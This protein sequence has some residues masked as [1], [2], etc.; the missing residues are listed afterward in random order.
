MKIV[1][2]VLLVFSVGFSAC[3]LNKNAQE[4]NVPAVIF[5]IEVGSDRIDSSG[6]EA[7]AIRFYENG[8]YSHF[9]HNFYAFGNWSWNEEKKRAT[10]KPIINKYEKNDQQYKI[11]YRENNDYIIKKVIE[12]NGKLLV[13]NSDNQALGFMQLKEPDPFSQEMNTWRVKPQSSESKEAIKRRTLNYLQFLIVY[14]QFIKENEL[15]FYTYGWFPTPIQMQ[16]ANGVRMSYSD[17]L[18]DWNACFYNIEEATE[19]YKLL[20]GNIRNCKIKNMESK[21]ER[22]IDYLQQLIAAINKG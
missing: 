17:E 13:E 11:L 6:N 21:A 7:L 18:N 20:S 15:N 2:W 9:G 10:L 4:K 22:N 16:Y 5:K 8:K 19:A 1:I 12:K 14:N 3:S